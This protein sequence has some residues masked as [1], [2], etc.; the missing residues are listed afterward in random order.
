MFKSRGYHDFMNERTKYC[1]FQSSGV[2]Y[3]KI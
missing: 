2:E 3:E 1:E